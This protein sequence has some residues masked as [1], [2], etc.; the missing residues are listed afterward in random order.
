MCVFFLNVALWGSILGWFVQALLL[1][2]PRIK[3]AYGLTDELPLG[4]AFLVGWYAIL[5]TTGAIT[6][7][8]VLVRV[9]G[10][11]LV[12]IFLYVNLGDVFIFFTCSWAVTAVFATVGL[13]VALKGVNLYWKH[14]SKLRARSFRVADLDDSS[15]D[16]E[17]E[18]SP[19]Q[20]P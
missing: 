19:P 8:A 20:G 10:P 5:G 15:N 11:L 17:T 18:S 1:S 3:S 14:A 2:S 4:K 13:L 9:A 12:A 16:I 6:V 7:L